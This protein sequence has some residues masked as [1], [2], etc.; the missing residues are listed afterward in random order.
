MT[1]AAIVL[2]A[3]LVIAALARRIKLGDSGLYTVLVLAAPIV[4]STGIFLSYFFGRSAHPS[5]ARFF[6]TL[7]V[8]LAL[9]PVI[10]RILKPELI[11]ARFLLIAAT[12]W[13]GVRAGGFVFRDEAGQP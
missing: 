4:V 2:L 8:I 1:A 7:C 11:S 3:Y 12:V 9:V 13:S 10:A 6:I 5:S